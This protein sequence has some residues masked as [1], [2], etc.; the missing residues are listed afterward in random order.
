[1]THECLKI[2]ERILEIHAQW[3]HGLPY[4]L[5]YTVDG[6][7]CNHADNLA[8]NA[9]R[10][11]KHLAPTEKRM[12]NTMNSAH[13]QAP[14]IGIIPNDTLGHNMAGPG[15][16]DWE[17][18][19]VLAQHL[20]V[21]LIFP[22]M[23]K[24]DPA[25]TPR[26][27]NG[28][29]LPITLHK[30]TDAA[31]L[32]TFAA[33][34]DVLMTRGTI[35]TAYPFL[36]QLGKPLV[37]DIYIPFL[38]ENL[39]RES[40]ADDL[41]QISSLEGDV[42]ALRLQLQAGDFFI[43]ADEKQRDYWLGMLAAFG[44]INPYTYRQDATLR[45]LIDLVPFG[46][47]NAPPVHNK[48]VLK[49]VYPGIAANDKVIFWGGG[50]WNWL[51][52]VTL[53]R[54]MAQVCN[55]RADVKLFFPGIKRP[56]PHAPVPEAVT[57][58]LQVSDDLGLTGRHVF[59][60]DWMPYAERHNYL[61]E[62]DIGASLHLEHIETHFA[63]RTRMLDYIWTGLP[64]LATRGDVLGQMLANRGLARLVAPRDVDGVAQAILELLA[65]PDLRSAHAAEFAKLAADY[66]WTQVAQPLLH[67][68]Q[69]P[70]FAADRQ[71]IAARR[72]DTAGPNSL[73][74]KAWRALRMGGVT[75]LW[76]QAVQYARWQA[77]IR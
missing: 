69:N 59:F 52:A 22:P 41:R 54:A 27:Q 45:R 12:S 37:V 5:W 26:Q 4:L 73:P 36:T 63:F 70:T 17:L 71:Y 74:E 48:Q 13:H 2:Y 1:M 60:N 61:L 53:I 19:H 29:A 47:Q 34:C 20:R 14:T 32:R 16:R 72:L 30:C 18:A 65:Q 28:I 24:L 25:L 10:I 64:V 68:C 7:L 11:T 57:E 77:R 23:V 75:G 44:R 39:E 62:A 67:F 31:Q 43:C 21:Q 50:I 46:V 35:L 58:A 3:R 9:Y 66:R 6:F 40:H 55:Q 8:N 42:G 15:I 49:G 51:D 38:L 56:T 76:R 33:Q